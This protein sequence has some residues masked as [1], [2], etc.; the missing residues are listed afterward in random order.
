MSFSR[1]PFRLAIA[2][3]ILGGVLLTACSSDEGPPDEPG[4]LVRLSFCAGAEP[5]W[6]AVQD[7]DA[8]WKRLLP[9]VT[10]VY[11]A[12]FAAS[13]GGVAYVS[14]GGNNLVVVYGDLTE[15]A[16]T[17]CT[18]GF[19]SLNGSV[20]GL[21]SVEGADVWFGR[22]FASVTAQRPRFQFRNVVDGQQD[23]FAT[24]YTWSGNG[25]QI[26]NRLVIRREQNLASG[27]LIAP[28]NFG[29]SESFA[30]AFATAS[31]A[32]A[33][34]AV[35]VDLISSWHGRASTALLMYSTTPG[36]QLYPSVP[37]D[38][39]EAGELSSLQAFTSEQ[40][41]GRAAAAYFRAPAD[42]VVTLGPGLSTPLVTWPDAPASLRP[43]LQLPSQPEYGRQARVTYTQGLDAVSVAVTSSYLGGT[44]PTWD[45]QVPDLSSVEGWNDAWGFASASG[46]LWLV[47]AAGGPDR[48]LGD[49]V[50]DG[51]VFRSADF[52]GSN[53]AATRAARVTGRPAPHHGGFPQPAQP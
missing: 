5:V 29:S 1:S 44:P 4:T 45:I 49:V 36:P 43:R 11:D 12:R 3:A 52:N 32:G 8:A 2:S 17:A 35:P 16:S 28:I 25:G 33:S 23:L 20:A 40:P 30:P 10:G 42:R 47:T 46:V 6:L 53:E 50:R 18:P 41:G 34:E 21:A 22:S 19:N 48:Y 37:L 27:S 31:V 51:D 14:G 39:L 38:R 7:G 15:L 13:R 26:A 9:R 24:R